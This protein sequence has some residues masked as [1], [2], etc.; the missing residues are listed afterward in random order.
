M[1]GVLG[2]ARGGVAPA[3]TPAWPCPAVGVVARAS[4]AAPQGVRGAPTDTLRVSPALCAAAL[5]LPGVCAPWCGVAPATGRPR[6]DR[7]GLSAQLRSLREPG[8]L[9]ALKNDD[10]AGALA[11]GRGAGTPTRVRAVRWP[12][13]RGSSCS[14]AAALWKRLG[15]C[16]THDGW[17]GAPVGI[18]PL[19]PT[20]ALRACGAASEQAATDDHLMLG[21]GP[22]LLVA[23]L[24]GQRERR[25]ARDRAVSR[26]EARGCVRST[27]VATRRAC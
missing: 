18:A 19:V 22:A 20:G 23:G 1:L 7:R 26:D 12:V 6:A 3:Q 13:S 5:L 8:L 25:G 21:C 27:A 2:P 15:G 10:R 4:T 14:S 11:L 24:V 16:G 9:G 17:Q